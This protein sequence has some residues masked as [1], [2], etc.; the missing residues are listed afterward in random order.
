MSTA[1]DTIKALQAE[2][3]SLRAEVQATQVS[4]SETAPHSEARASRRQLLRLAG[5][6]AAGGAVATVAG[7]GQAAA[8]DGLTIT[9]ASATTTANAVMV[10]STN[11]VT[12]TQKFLFRGGGS[13][14]TNTTSGFDGVLAV[15]AAGTVDGLNV[16]TA[17]GAAARF[18]SNT[19]IGVQSTGTT[20]LE[21]FAE[22]SA[23]AHHILFSAL[24][25]LPSSRS[26]QQNAVDL[27]AD[28]LWLST[29]AAVNPWRKLAGP[30]SAGAFHAIATARVYDS[31][32]T[33]GVGTVVGVIASGANRIIPVRDQRDPGTGAVT[34]ADVVPDKASAVAYNL[35][36]VGTVG[37]N[38]F[39]AVEPGDVSAFGG[40]ALNWS[41]AGITIA[42]ASTAKLDL[43]RQLKVF[44][45]G[46]STSCHFIIDI[47][48]YYL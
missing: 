22:G 31:R 34:T 5:G 24:P 40:S 3:A 29:T 26:S 4:A 32:K 21:L 12:G 19:S 23:T 16:R 13:T 35:T 44:C 11:A 42:N 28:G 30:T 15:N 48:G 1:N 20:A 39:L 45:G 7:V 41:A 33:M 36:A 9:A 17:G 47:V 8:T 38:G 2:V 18:R 10:S 14:A 43:A 25:A 27:C 46:T 6:L 37:T